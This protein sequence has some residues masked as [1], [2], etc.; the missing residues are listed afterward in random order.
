MLKLGIWGEKAVVE[1]TSTPRDS[2]DFSGLK[3]D[4]ARDKSLSHR[5]LIFAALASGG[6][7]RIKNCL[8][9]DDVQMT[10][11]CLKKMNT[12][13]KCEGDLMIVNGGGETLHAP[14]EVLHCGNS[15][16]TI[17]LLLGVVSG[18]NIDAKFDGDSSLR[19][20]PMKR[21]IDP[22]N[23][24]GAKISDNPDSSEGY[25]IEA[26]ERSGKQL[27]EGAERIDSSEK[28]WR[29]EIASAQI[30][31]ALL[32]YSLLNSE[33][34]VTDYRLCGMLKSR[35][36]TEKFL[37]HFLPDLIDVNDQEI[38]LKAGEKKIPSFDF[39]V[40]KDPSSLAFFIAL[41]TVKGR[42]QWTVED[43][44]K[45]PRREGFL[46]A[47]KK[48][49]LSITESDL[50]SSGIEETVTLN[51]TPTVNLNAIKI[52]AHEIPDLIDE[53]PILAL[54]AT[55]AEGESVFCGVDELRH[56][57]SDRVA[58]ITHNLKLLG[59]D[60]VCQGSTLRIFGKSQLKKSSLDSFGDHRIVMMNAIAAHISSESVMVKDAELAKISYPK[61]WEDLKCLI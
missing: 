60:V 23:F 58:A 9:S 18:L 13:I 14:R 36:H 52:E 49:G 4:S 39:Q 19:K 35:D 43:C 44:L 33:T 5:A 56:K 46:R 31:S 59:A 30:K 47:V 22:L 57:E 2:Y 3:L 15:G 7:S 10:I 21:V 26:A 38:I 40:P 6:Q 34:S 54:L 1:F 16:T 55:Q 12:T 53:L 32:F 20:R 41:Y 11:N 28:E 25:F 50:D 17:R 8:Q 29:L 42:G 37:Q 24:W 27:D 48:M 61:F 45:N 51:F